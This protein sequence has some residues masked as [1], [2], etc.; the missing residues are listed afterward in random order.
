MT[1]TDY[2]KLNIYTPFCLYVSARI[3]A[4]IPKADPEDHSARSS[5]RFL[6]S[7]SVAFKETIPLADSYLLQ[8]DLEGSGLAALQ[9]NVKFS[10]LEKS[11][12]SIIISFL[13]M[14]C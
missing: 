2:D 12:V 3:F 8:L 6:L 13:R 5:L 4:R 7:A 11:L 14:I 9:D 10:G 1:S